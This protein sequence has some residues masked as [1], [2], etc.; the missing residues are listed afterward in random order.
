VTIHSFKF[1]SFIP[2]EKVKIRNE[3]QPVPV[4]LLLHRLDEVL[5]EY[6]D[7][8]LNILREIAN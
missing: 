5:P 2:L 6:K 7:A 1:G 3:V 4:Y 8:M